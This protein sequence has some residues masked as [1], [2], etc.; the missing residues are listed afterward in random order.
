MFNHFKFFKRIPNKNNFFQKTLLY[1]PLML[2]PKIAKLEDGLEM[3][4]ITVGEYENRIRN[5]ASI[6]KRFMVFANVRDPNEIK[7]NYFQFL[8]SLVPFQH[9]KTRSKAEVE[10]V[11]SK[12][13]HFNEI[14]NRVDI[15]KDG[16]INFEEFVILCIFMNITEEEF[17]QSMKKD[18]ITREELTEIIMNEAKSN[19]RITD[20]SV[21]DGRSVK[22]DYNTL[23]K[24]VVE[25]LGK[26]FPNNK[27]TQNDFQKVKQDLF[28]F[29]LF[30]EFYRIPSDKMDYIS[31]ENFA[32]VILSYVDP[33]KFSVI[34][35]KIE[36]KVINLDVIIIYTGLC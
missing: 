16:F 23:F 35:K 25:F 14:L 9:I 12:N 36:D 32:Y 7:M 34:K 20:K 6:E 18:F 26:E 8:Y 4:D 5:F 30:Y 2:L 31:L 13:K 27:I 28:L 17:K 21:F 3:K 10:E 11:L 33:Y 24:Y 19:I 15:N 1:F 22:T 29:M